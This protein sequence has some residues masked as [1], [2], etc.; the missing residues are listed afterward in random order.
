MIEGNGFPL[1]HTRILPNDPCPCGSG[2]K[3]KR[4]CGTDTSFFYSKLNEKQEAE[5]KA[6]EKAEMKQKEDEAAKV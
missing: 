5:R 1:I 3:A 2:K 4:C 6:R